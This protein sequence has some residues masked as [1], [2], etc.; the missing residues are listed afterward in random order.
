MRKNSNIIRAFDALTIVKGIN[1]LGGP[2]KQVYYIESDVYAPDRRITPLLL[3]PYVN[4]SDPNGIITAGDKVSEL[5]DGAW[6][7]DAI[8]PKNRVTKSSAGSTLDDPFTIGDNHRLMVRL[9]TDKSVM[10]FFEGDYYDSRKG[11]KI[12][13][14]LSYMLSTT[15]NSQNKPAPKVLLSKGASYTYNP[16]DDLTELIIESQLADDGKLLRGAVEWCEVEV[17]RLLQFRM[18]CLTI[19]QD[20]IRIS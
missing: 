8:D 1:S 15:H 18:L 3:Q 17:L 5:V 20:S 4:V 14:S 6:Y 12:H 10:L 19:Y 16:L 13:I 2:D 7:V 9:N 11:S